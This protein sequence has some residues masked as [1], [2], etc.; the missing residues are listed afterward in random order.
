MRIRTKF[1]LSGVALCL[2]LCSLPAVAQ[3][4][5][6]NKQQAFPATVPAGNYSGL[7]WLGG[8]RYAVAN[9]KSAQA[10]FHLMS[11][12]I[13]SIS[14]QLLEVRAD[15]FVTS[16]QPNRDEE[17]VCYVPQWNTV[18]ISGEADG[19]IIEYQMDSQLT[20]RRLN[21]PDEFRTAYPNAGFE[22]LTYQQ[23]T[24]RFW[25]T[26]EQTLACDGEQ[27]TIINK[28][29]NRL[30]LQSFDDQLQP[31]EQYWYE[32]DATVV[33][34]TEGTCVL[35]VSGLAALDDGRV[36]VLERE[37]YRKKG[38]SDEQA[39]GLIQPVEYDT[40]NIGN[41]WINY[42]NYL[43][44]TL[45]PAVIAFIVLM[46]T[47]YVI[48]RERQERTMKSWLRRA[49]GNTL[50]ALIGKMIPYTAW[51]TLLC[52]LANLI[53]LQKQPCGHGLMSFYLC[54]AGTCITPN[55]C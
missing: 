55:R 22:A 11:I 27:P 12:R 14:G 49:G 19:Q 41:P 5:V 50:Y 53:I 51:Y 4:P 8:D 31:A 7:A 35:G 24:H 17:G 16:G 3:Q 15:S 18:W 44:T 9:D 47:A 43:M 37:V 54:L 42:G 25:T 52:L 34:Q 30:R 45:I 21:I 46:H 23:A 1:V 33:E 48:A 28:V 38:Y 39:M 29:A 2:A 20:G 40:R 6:L 32:S 13:D 26:S 10:G 36:V